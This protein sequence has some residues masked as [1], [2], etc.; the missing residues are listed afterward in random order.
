MGNGACDAIKAGAAH[1]K[2]P[3][4]DVVQVPVFGRFPML[5]TQFSSCRPNL[6]LWR[7]IVVR[8]SHQRLRHVDA[9]RE[10]CARKRSH[11]TG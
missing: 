11:Y 6:H 1:G 4:L 8:F 10:R 3:N 2:D 5:M 9:R 7:T